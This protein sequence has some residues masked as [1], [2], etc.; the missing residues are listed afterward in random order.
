MKPASAAWRK[1]E[2]VHRADLDQLAEARVRDLPA[3]EVARDHPDDVAPG[4]E[5]GVCHDAHQADGS[6]AVDEGEALSATSV[7]SERAA[8]ANSARLP[9]EDAQ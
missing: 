2:C 3:E 9:G 1:R 4:G 6:A 5:G 8:S 7:P